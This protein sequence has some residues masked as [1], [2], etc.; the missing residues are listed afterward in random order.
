M[1]SASSQTEG[2]SGA[3]RIFLTLSG[4]SGLFSFVPQGAL[5][6]S[7]GP[8][9]GWMLVPVLVAAWAVRR[10]RVLRKGPPLADARAGA[11]HPQR[12]RRGRAAGIPGGG[13]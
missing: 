12:V 1:D 8:T 7:L 5:R 13:V 4:L 6:W 3:P 11:A 9:I 2:R 10:L